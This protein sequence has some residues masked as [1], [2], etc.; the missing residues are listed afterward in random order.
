MTDAFSARAPRAIV[1]SL[2]LALMGGAAHAAVTVHQGAAGLTAFNAAAGNPGVAISFDALS[3]DINGNTIGGVTFASFGGNTLEV[4]NGADTV[5]GPNYA[6]IIN[7]NTNKLFATSGDKV[8]SP[9]GTELVPGPATGEQDSLQLDFA[10]PFAAFGLDILFQSYD[11]A[12]LV[13]YLVY[14][15]NLVLIALGGIIGNGQG[16]GAPGGSVFFGVTSDN[17]ATHIGRIVF[18]ESDSNNIFPDNN[19]GYDTF[20]FGRPDGAIPEP[21]T[22]A[23]MI[24]G[25]GL[26][27]AAMRRRGRTAHA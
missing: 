10:S 11:A 6:G 21:G 27:G 15:Q 1:L 2:A 24:L 18:V 3:G 5:T 20:R 7:A 25:F 12:P 19:V 22:W 16:G 8:L 4:V 17:A 26:A 9:G 23:L 14:D 13:N